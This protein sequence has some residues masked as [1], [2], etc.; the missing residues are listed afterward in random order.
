MAAEPVIVP[1]PTFADGAA[2]WKPIGATAVDRVTDRSGTPAA[3]VMRRSAR[4]RTVGLASAASDPLPEAGTRVHVA[5]QVKSRTTGR[6]IQFQLRELAE[7][8]SVVTRFT[9]VTMP[10]DRGWHWTGAVITTTRDDS[11][12]SLKVRQPR[13]AGAR[14]LQV[15]SIRSDQ[16]SPQA[17]PPG[18]HPHPDP[19]PSPPDQAHDDP[20]PPPPPASPRTCRDTDYAKSDQGRLVFS[21]EFSGSSVDSSKWRVRDR[22]SLSFDKARILARNVTV[23]DGVLDIAGK[24]ETVDGRDYTTGYV[25][26]IGKF[27][28]KYGRWEMRAKVPTD[29]TRTRGV[30]PAFWLRGDRTPGEIDIMETWGQPATQSFN[31]AVSNSWTVW[32][33][34]NVGG[35]D[36]F[37]GWS[38]GPTGPP[39]YGAFHV[40]AVNWS[41]TCMVF[42]L[43]GKTVGTVPTDAAPWLTSS[44]DSP[45]NIRLNMQVGST[46]WGNPDDVNTKP[47]F[48]FLVDYVRAYAPD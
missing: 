33:D 45:F 4:P 15:R 21:D 10:R 8:G 41:P 9:G 5:A 22:D 40:F 37:T 11:R 42:S 43:D 35:R 7:D 34:T 48:N 23:H 44:F 39:I 12:V 20:Q 32:R 25:D 38:H 6:R 36:K 17:P 47:E 28:Q 31:P 29:S 30:W 16:T 13:V 3:R 27:S 46:F 19:D 14:P 1:N 18:P 24:R 26:T 2:G